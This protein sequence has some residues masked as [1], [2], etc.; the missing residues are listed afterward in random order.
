MGD[1]TETVQVDYDPRV[2]TYEQLLQVFWDSHHPAGK[3]WS[4][5]YMNA[6]FYHND[7]QRQLA[8]ASKEAMAKKIGRPVGSAVVP[9]RSFTLAEDYHQ[10]YLL[11]GNKKLLDE[12]KKVYP[13]PQDFIDSTAVTRLNG[14]VGR[15]GTK[16]QLSRDIDR[17]GLS[18][19]GQDVLAWLVGR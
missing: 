14:Y 19:E 6:V 18:R 3:A 12:M 9:L 2:I 11:K 5:Q 15:Y 10:K 13:R 17:L 8:T 7:R 1:H 16:E 4:R